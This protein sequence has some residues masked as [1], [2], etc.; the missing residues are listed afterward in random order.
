VSQL[1]LISSACV[2]SCFFNTYAL[3]CKILGTR[4]A[5]QGVTLPKDVAKWEANRANNE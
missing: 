1:E 4:S 5:L 2:N 3:L